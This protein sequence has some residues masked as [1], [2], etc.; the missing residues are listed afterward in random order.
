MSFA[1]DVKKEISNVIV[2]DCCLKAELYAICK[3]KSTMIISLNKLKIEFRTT[4][5]N[6][7]R[8]ISFLFKKLYNVK[9][10]MLLKQQEKL[11]YKSIYYLEIED[12]IGSV[13]KDLDIINDNFSMKSEISN[14]LLNKDC[15][16]IS[17]LRGLFLA[18][19]SI[20]DPNKS[21]YH[22]ELVIDDEDLALF[23][24]GILKNVEIEP[25]IIKRDKGVVVYLKKS[26]QIGDF[27]RYIGAV[28]SLFLFEDLRIKKD[29]SNY[30]NRMINCD[31]AN[32]QK[33]LST[34]AKQLENIALIKDTIGF[35]NLTQRILDAILLRNT[36]PDDSLSQLSDK[37]EETIGKYISK[38]G[39]SHCY[40]DIEK[41]AEEIRNNRK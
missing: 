10:N 6:T 18:R 40:K 16:K 41:M 12:N 2:D 1:S 26:E 14:R 24:I 5:I 25:K 39:L 7:A 38:S 30:V 3:L 31:V 35:L 29:L 13:L 15:C 11:D 21:N 32:E 36:Y 28:N 34:A 17:F 37:S 27:L 33:A 19:G 22:L 20:N 8:R 9:S 4:S 23:V